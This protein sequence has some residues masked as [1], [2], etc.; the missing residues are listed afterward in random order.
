MIR[1]RNANAW[2]E[3]GGNVD[4]IPG[5]E[6]GVRSL[7]TDGT[8]LYSSGGETLLALARPVEAY[9]I[10]GGCK[11]IARKAFSG[12]GGL[13]HLYLPDGLEEIGAFAFANSGIEEL[14]CPGSVHGFLLALSGNAGYLH[15]PDIMAQYD[16]CIA[17]ARDYHVP[18]SSDNASAYEQVQLIIDRLR[19]SV[20]LTQANRQRYHTVLS[21][22][23][24]EICVDIARHDD[25]R[26]I[27][28]LAD[29]GFLNADNLEGVITAVAKLQDAAMTGYLLEMKRLRFGCASIDFDL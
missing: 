1:Q 2:R 4:Y 28:A 8:C 19:D 20:L 24:E 15:L 5:V 7:F 23:I 21:A 17:A 26:A 11:R 22:N 6:I 12:F 29:L 27:S 13:K 10:A 3:W 18:R 9:V 16:S 14:V 25:R